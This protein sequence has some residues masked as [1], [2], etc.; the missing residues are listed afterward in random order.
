MKAF[1][2]RQ[3]SGRWVRLAFVWLSVL[4][5][6]GC[7][8]GAY[9]LRADGFWLAVMS[10]VGAAVFLLAP[11]FWFERTLKARINQVVDK[12]TEEVSGLRDRVK[13]VE[14]WTADAQVTL[15]GLSTRAGQVVQ[16]QVHHLKTLSDAVDGDFSAKNLVALL[17]ESLNIGA[18]D[19]SGLRVK[20]ELGDVRV[21]FGIET[22]DSD[23]TWQLAGPMWEHVLRIGLEKRPGEYI[24]HLHWLPDVAFDEV[25][26][27]YISLLQRCGHWISGLDCSQVFRDMVKTVKRAIEERL[28]GRLRGGSVVEMPNM[29]WI[30][31][32]QGLESLEHTYSIDREQLWE[33][34][35]AEHMSEKTWVDMPLFRQALEEAK[36]VFWALA[37]G[38]PLSK[39]RR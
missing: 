18:I 7:L 12:T 16:A 28:N 1:W 8:V 23:A 5:G 38:G 39:D 10:N 9:Y 3:Q 33:H 20:P 35:W 17:E 11:I 25:L 4:V 37:P 36:Q 29:K 22:I 24:A 2:A 34:D 32:N 6:I 15:E 30:I 14:E 19:E 13:K 27:D 31:T 26:L 21:R